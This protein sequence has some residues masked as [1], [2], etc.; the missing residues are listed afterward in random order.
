MV[1]GCK[2]IAGRRFAIEPLA[3]V[4]DWFDGTLRGPPA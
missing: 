2:G 3:G 1:A 4:L